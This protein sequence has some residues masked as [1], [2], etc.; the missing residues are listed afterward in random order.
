VF[1]LILCEKLKEEEGTPEKS[2]VN[3]FFAFSY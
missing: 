2:F 1:D 3:T